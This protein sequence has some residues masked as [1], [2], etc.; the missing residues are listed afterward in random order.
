M[1]RALPWPGADTPGYI[2]THA[3]G[4]FHDGP[5]AGKTFWTGS[6][7]ADVNQ[8]LQT[9][10]GYSSWRYPP[11]VYMCMSR[12]AQTRIDKNGKVRAAKHQ[13]HALALKSL[14]A[15][16]DVKPPPRGYASLVEAADAVAAFCTAI[17]IP[18]PTALVGSGGGLHA[19]WISDREL[20]PDEWQP[21]A[22]GLKQ[23]MLNFGLRC[24]AGVTGDS[25]RVL[26]VPG[27]LNHKTNPP[28]PVRLLGLRGD[29]YDFAKELQP[30]LQLAPALPRAKATFVLP[31][32]PDPAFDGMPIE[33]LSLGIR[34]PLPPLD[35]RPIIY[36]CPHFQEAV[37]T[38]GADFDQTLWHL[39]TLSATWMEDGHALAHKM[40]Q[41]YPGYSYG[42][43][44]DLWERK[45]GDRKGHR[46]GWPSCNA[47]RDAGCK[48]CKTC[49][50]LGAGKSPL[51]LAR[52]PPLQVGAMAT[53][54][55][56][57]T[58]TPAPA[59]V[60]PSGGPLTYALAR[61]F[62]P[63]TDADLPYG[64][65]MKDDTVHKVVK[66]KDGNGGYNTDLVP[67][68]YSHIYEPWAQ[69]DP[70]AALVFSTHVDLGTFRQ[71]IIPRNDLTTMK[72]QGKLVEQG[73][74]TVTTSKA[75]AEEFIVS[76]LAKLNA[77][78]AA[79]TTAPFGWVMKD[80]T[81]E[82][83]SFGGLIYRTDGTSGPI[84]MGDPKL[85]AMYAPKGDAAVWHNAFKELV[86]AQKRPGLEAIVA[87]SFGAPL[88]FGAGEY[89]VMFSV[90]GDTGANKT[91]AARLACAV[92]GNPILTKE[93]ATATTKSVLHRLG[94]TKNLP[95]LWDEI[96]DE[97][98]QSHVYDVLYMGTGG[99][100]GSRLNQDVTQ[101]D[102]GT[103][104]T[105]TGILS[106][107]SFSNFVLKKNSGT[108]AG[109]MRVF[110]WKE[111]RPGVGAPGR[112]SP[113]DAGRLLGDLD[114]NYGRVGA[115]YAE[116]LGQNRDSVFD[117]TAVNS[118]WFEDAVRDP[119]RDSGDER[120]WIAFAAAVQT[121]AELASF[122]LGVPFNLEALRAFLVE[123]I[124]LQ[125]AR[126]AE[127]NVD[128]GSLD[129]TEDYLTRFLKEYRPHTLRTK[130]V[131]SGNQTIKPAVS[132]EA[133]A[134]MRDKPVI[135]EWAIQGPQ[136]VLKFSQAELYRWLRRPDINGDPR[137]M[138]DGLRN[139]FAAIAV[140]GTLGAGTILHE[141]REMLVTIPVTNTSPLWGL[142]T[143]EV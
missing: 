58:T 21:Y 104:Q 122:R 57:G 128:G 64:F 18:P 19:H 120:Y 143:G 55:A 35:P 105:I 129:H 135:I 99:S 73:V 83:F 95:L 118:R 44:E 65:A 79:T 142:M 17:G 4:K 7:N 123:K 47:F 74:L 20:T 124:L 86:S 138:K 39:T 12:Q 2:N 130:I 112:I 101:R 67:V 139:H 60:G 113:S 63:L 100:E 23:A 29:D 87:A 89:G 30:L 53:Y 5:E 116:F 108:T 70:N 62:I 1:L 13:N 77:A 26:R 10:H 90:Y 11:D 52:V 84:G 126:S 119:S 50:H 41:G 32:R 43:T 88:M 81:C 49:P 31:G 92:W 133:P 40:A 109:L 78:A 27:T 82:G 141:G 132:I 36:G 137:M 6:P 76:W 93:A 97:K 24:D 68:F 59:P 9:A 48:H 136:G 106:N 110:E 3:M 54:V 117:R 115:L 140:R 121:G 22:D 28:K 16:I 107:P 15:D 103:W 80:N 127:E 14:F 38:G 94:Q 91:S 96:K 66:S 69:A 125:R 75:Y 111:T 42:E 134:P 46:L 85:K 33:S 98:T 72:L 37:L 8:F 25:A 61:G 102:K 45:I 131:L 114:F 71:S 56:N 34:D 51:N